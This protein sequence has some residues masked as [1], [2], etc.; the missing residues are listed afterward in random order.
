MK[1]EK[2]H[3]H[4]KCH[5][6]EVIVKCKYQKLGCVWSGPRRIQNEHFHAGINFDNIMKMLQDH[7]EKIEVLGEDIDGWIE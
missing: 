6:Q 5:C 7:E 4:L 1:Y 3:E 2:L